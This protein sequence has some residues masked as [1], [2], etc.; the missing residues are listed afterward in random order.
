MCFVVSCSCILDAR[1]GKRRDA[2]LTTPGPLIRLAVAGNALSHRGINGERR[3][4]G[5]HHSA[6]PSL[7]QA[8][9]QYD[10][11]SSPAGVEELS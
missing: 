8:E 2:N 5:I 9:S 11:G 4:E 10:S 1:A 7:R 6:H 3:G